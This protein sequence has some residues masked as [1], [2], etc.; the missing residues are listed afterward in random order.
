LQLMNSLQFVESG[1]GP[2]Q[3]EGGRFLHQTKLSIDVLEL[4]RVRQC[5]PGC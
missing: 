3:A 1:P 5:V 2:R 4:F